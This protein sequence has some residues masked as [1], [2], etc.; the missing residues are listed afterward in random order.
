MSKIVEFRK[1]DANRWAQDVVAEINATLPICGA[2]VGRVGG[3]CHAPNET[4]PVHLLGRVSVLEIDQ[5]VAS[6]ERRSGSCCRGG[7]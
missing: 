4:V 1:S 6:L 2:T 7:G 5:S 3:S